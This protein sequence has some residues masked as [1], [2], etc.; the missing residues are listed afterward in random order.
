MLLL[1][2]GDPAITSLLTLS[3]RGRLEF[4]GLDS[5]VS[6]VRFLGAHV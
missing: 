2:K 3:F 5:E 6:A 1:V 4:N